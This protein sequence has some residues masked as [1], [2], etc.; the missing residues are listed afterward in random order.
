VAVSFVWGS[1]SSDTD[2]MARGKGAAR[3]GKHDAVTINCAAWIIYRLIIDI[4]SNRLAI[5]GSLAEQQENDTKALLL[6]LC[7]QSAA[8]SWHLAKAL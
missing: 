3:K 6:L 7:Q 1:S 5:Q 4:E 8:A 2:T